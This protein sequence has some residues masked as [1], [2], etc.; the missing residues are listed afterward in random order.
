MPYILPDGMPETM[1]EWCLRAGIIRRKYVVRWNLDLFFDNQHSEAPRDP[2]YSDTY[3][4]VS[5]GFSGIA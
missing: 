5:W 3:W 4:D 2:R 1:S